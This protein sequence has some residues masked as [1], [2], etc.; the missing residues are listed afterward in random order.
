MKTLSEDL[1]C[2]VVG[3]RLLS[4]RENPTAPASAEIDPFVIIL[5]WLF[6]AKDQLKVLSETVSGHLEV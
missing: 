6:E 1:N 4:F 2:L 3:R 5:K